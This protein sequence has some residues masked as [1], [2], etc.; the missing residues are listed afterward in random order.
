M[1]NR[2][3]NEEYSCKLSNY[4]IDLLFKKN[5]PHLDSNTMREIVDRIKENMK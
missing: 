1:R 4:A 2:Y 5:R 3:R